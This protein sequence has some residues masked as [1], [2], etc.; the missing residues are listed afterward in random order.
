M[1]DDDG[2]LDK[3]EVNYS[4]GLRDQCKMCRY[5]INLH[6]QWMKG[7][8]AKVKGSIDKEYWCKEFQRV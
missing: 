4:P 1:A 2:K 5:F 6:P 3:A 7:K 8:C